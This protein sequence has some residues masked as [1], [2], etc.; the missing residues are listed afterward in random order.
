MT[1]LEVAPEIMGLEDDEAAQLIREVLQEEGVKH[2]G[3]QVKQPL[4][5]IHTGCTVSAVSH[6]PA[7]TPQVSCQ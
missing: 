2:L 5:R 4:L 6:S 1:V 3:Q 7:A